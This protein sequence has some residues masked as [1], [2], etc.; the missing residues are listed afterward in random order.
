[1]IPNATG[2]VDEVRRRPVAALE[3]LADTLVSDNVRVET[4]ARMHGRLNGGLL[5]ARGE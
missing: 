5:A 2:V 1:M 3:Q 4:P